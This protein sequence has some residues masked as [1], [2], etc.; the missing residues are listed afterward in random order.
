M[1]AH[2]RAQS[3]RVA[4][5]RQRAAAAAVV[6]DLH[7]PACIAGRRQACCLRSASSREHHKLTTAGGPEK[8]APVP[9]SQGPHIAECVQRLAEVR[10]AI[11]RLCSGCWTSLSSSLPAQHTA[12]SFLPHVRATL[13]HTLHREGACRPPAAQPRSTAARPQRLQA[14]PQGPGAAGTRPPPALAAACT[15]P[16][17]HLATLLASSTRQAVAACSSSSA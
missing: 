3:E 4:A 5:S 11:K 16:P 13:R 9:P 1:V 12:R 10:Q 8:L 6:V 14:H 2:A 15:A 7:V 17:L